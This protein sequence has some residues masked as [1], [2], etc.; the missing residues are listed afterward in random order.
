MRRLVL[1]RHGQTAWNASGRAQGHADVELDE[2]GHLQAKAVAPAVAAYSPVLLWSSDLL[3]ARQ[4]AAQVAAETGLT[5]VLDA[6]LREYAVGENRMG[7]TLG[8]YAERFPEEYAHLV[9]GEMR[10]IPGRETEP[11]TRA[12]MLG[13]LRDIA[14]RVGAGSTALVVSHGAALKLGVSA[15]L[16]WP[17]E[18]EDSV[19]VLDNCAWV[20]LEESRSR[21]LPGPLRWRLAA[22]NL[23]AGDPDFASGPGV[24]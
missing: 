3:R 16:G 19:A 4:T 22:Y 14:G 18:A 12:R 13:V 24:G 21:H 8:E 20:V 23:R 11:D 15:F 6:R 9:A 5:P 17:V 10:L 2:I 1:L 7:L